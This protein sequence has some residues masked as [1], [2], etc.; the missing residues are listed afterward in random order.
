MSML[1]IVGAV[2]IVIGLIPGVL[3]A[4][5][6]FSVVPSMEEDAEFPED[7]DDHFTYGGYLEKLDTS[8]GQ[9]PKTNFTVDRH[10]VNTGKMD[11]GHYLV[12]ETITATEEGT[13]NE[14]EDLNK[15]HKYEVHRKDLTLYGVENQDG[16]TDSFT[17]ADGV[18]WMFPIPADKDKD[19]EIWNMNILTHSTAKYQETKEIHG[20]E[21]YE[22]Y[23]IEEDWVIPEDQWP[24]LL[25]ALPE[26][27]KAG[28]EMSMTLWERAWVHP[29]SGAVVDYQKEVTVFLSFPEL[30]KVEYPEN[31]GSET[32]FDG[33]LTLFDQA[34]GTFVSMAGIS[35]ERT[36][37]WGSADNGTL[38]AEDTVSVYAP[39]GSPIDLL[40]STITAMFDQATGEHT[41]M[42][43]TGQYV[44]PPT[45]VSQENISIWDDGFQM[46]LN[47]EYIGTESEDFAPLE[48]YVFKIDVEGLA[49]YTKDGPAGTADMEMTY[50]IEPNTG[51]VL[52]V[53]K[54][55]WNYR[56]Q[57]ARRLPVDYTTID[58]TVSMNTTIIQINPMDETSNEIEI[59][60]EQ[61]INCTGYTDETLSVAKVQETV[62]KVG[63]PG[64]PVVSKFGVDAVTMEYVYVAGWSTVNRTGVFTFPVSLLNETREVTPSFLMYNS[65]LGQSVPFMLADEIE[66]NGLAAAVYKFQIADHELDHA[67]LVAALS[68]NDPGLPGATGLYS[69]NVTYTVD[70]DT[71]TILDVQRASTVQIVPPG[72]E[73]LWDNLDSTTVL[74]GQFMSQNITVTQVLRGEPAGQGTTLIN[75]TKTYKFD[76]GTDF[77]P[78]EYGEALINTSSHEML[79]PNGTEMGAYLLFPADPAQMA[80]YP[81]MFSFGG[82]IFTG[83]A[84]KGEESGTTV[85]YNFSETQEIDAGLFGAPGV[86]ANMTLSYDYLLDKISGMVLDVH[87]GIFVENETMIFAMLDFDADEATK[88]GAL[89]KNEVMKWSI[90]QIPKDILQ[91]EMEL[92]DME[93]A[94]NVAKA[95]VTQGLLDVADGDE[96]AMDLHI[97][98]NATTKATMKTTA[99]LM[100]TQLQSLMQ[101]Q[102]MK[103]LLENNDDVYMH[104]YYAQVETGE[105]SVEYWAEEA[106]H[107]EDQ[108][109]LYGTTL[110]IVGYIIT[111]VLVLVGIALILT[112]GKK[113]EEEEGSLEEEEEE[114]ET[115]ERTCASCGELIDDPEA[116]ECPECG[117]PITEEE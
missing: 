116:T 95:T 105:G 111:L 85:A 100:N 91:V 26:D 34:T 110:P 46:E 57:P 106:K 84:V 77:M 93:V 66:F 94:Y 72:Y 83:P 43:R 73:F 8:T 65:D 37:S 28:T 15:F 96:P 47:A 69:G 117:E 51:I 38:T 78:V 2:L 71:G 70:I 54:H 103:M 6:M 49:Y 92:Y 21:C 82:V 30:P 40:G 74:K 112:S 55:L 52:D 76:N 22:F 13:G 108:L 58:K 18:N 97:Y 9:F 109:A 17:D 113:P 60:V 75:M 89:M 4:A 1:K 59:V 87:V 24:A 81:M 27:I 3:G 79:Y 67:G 115:G 11:N 33:D 32:G 12:E 101:L 16:F 41:G 68:G 61:M 90:Y 50:W 56:A 102:G 20:V 29:I 23:G 86:P 31:Y 7:F 107:I 5:M 39:D 36:V 114:E 104:V 62:T 25:T 35:A 63:M 98:F 80:G 10:I 14:I 19:Y 64:G 42:G 48:A 99:Q 88:T 44:F 53:D 45:G